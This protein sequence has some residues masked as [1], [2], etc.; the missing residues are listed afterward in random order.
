MDF[1]RIKKLR[2][3]NIKIK[4]RKINQSQEYNIHANKIQSKKKKIFTLLVYKAPA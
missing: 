3:A 4:Q 1:I 2:Y